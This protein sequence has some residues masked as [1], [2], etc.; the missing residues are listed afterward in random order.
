MAMTTRI[1]NHRS[2]HQAGRE[3]G[4]RALLGLLAII[5]A[6]ISLTA[7]LWRLTGPPEVPSGL[8]DWQYTRDVLRGSRVATGD[9]VS[10]AAAIGWIVL[11]YL[12]VTVSLR[13]LSE[14]AAHL[15]D[16]ARWAR[17]MLRLSDTI[18]LPPVR[19][20]VD[21]ALAGTLVAAAWLRSGPSMA[22]A[23]DSSL[24]ATTAVAEPHRLDP[25]GQY[26]S[27]L[28]RVKGHIAPTAMS[29]EA[30]YTVAE[31]DSL[32]RIAEQFY[33]DGSL[34]PAI[35]DANAGRSMVTGEAFTDP[36]L[37]RPGW[38]LEIP[39]P[40]EGESPVTPNMMYEVKEGD[41]LWRIAESVL[42]SGLR[43]TE[44]WE[45]NRDRD[46]GGG[47]PF[48]EA[49]RIFPGWVLE[50]PRP[51][52]LT[53]VP[54]IEPI[55]SPIAAPAPSPAA[56]TSGPT[57]HTA[58][59]ASPSPTSPA[60]DTLA[61]IS[62]TLPESNNGGGT[63]DLPTP[64]GGTVL[65]AAAGVGTA[66]AFALVVRQWRRRSD[67]SGIA[68]MRRRPSVGDAARAD[69]A[70]R[71]LSSALRDLGFEDV[72]ILLVRETQRVLKFTLGCAPGDADALAH[73]RYE[74]A[75]RLACAVDAAAASRTRV[76]FTLSRF[77]RL[78][79]MLLDRATTQPAVLLLPL[80]ATEAGIHYLTLSGVQSILLIGN[81]GAT[82]HMLS[83][84]ISSVKALHSAEALR[85]VQGG[86]ATSMRNAEEIAGAAEGR[87]IPELA[88]ELEDSIVARQS[89]SAP[90]A[91]PATISLAY[92]SE[93]AIDDLHHLETAIHRGPEH[94][95]Y[96]ICVAPQPVEIGNMFG[97]RIAFESA[98]AE[99]DELVLTLGRDVPIVLKPVEVHAQPLRRH[100]DPPADP[101]DEHV[102]FE[103]E[104]VDSDFKPAEEPE[105]NLVGSPGEISPPQEQP[106]PPEGTAL[107][108]EP[109]APGAAVSQGSRQAAL[110][111]PEP[112]ETNESASAQRPIFEVRCFGTF[113]VLSNGLEV[114]GWT[115]QKARELLAYLIARGGARVS[116]EEAAD[117]LWPE[118]PADQ[119]EHLLSNAAY[120]V[121]R[122]LKIATASPNGRVLT[123]SEQKYQ[124]LSGVFRADLDA[125][126]AHLR[127]AESLEGS[128]AL[129]E[130]DRALSIY[131]GEF[132]GNEPYEWAEPYRRDYQRRF[133]TAAHQAGRLAIECRDVKK[134][135]AFYQAILDRDPIDE[136]A[137]RALMRCHAKL[138]DTNAVRRVYKM[139]RESLR[140]ELDDERAEALPE[141]VALVGELTR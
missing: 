120:Y 21:A 71:S 95:I 85:F 27:G 22:T 84:W 141:T 55:A 87:S 19:R 26:Q 56:S 139:L 98:D 78:A 112:E 10:I 102:R 106:A 128:E 132:M 46:M 18:T 20:T 86:R 137:A 83:S 63:P 24:V 9:A 107:I 82:G 115:I 16:R 65:A 105:E 134:A 94:G 37:I 73:A 51:T 103:V 126:D 28:D 38:T 79:G 61:P 96:T 97:A 8:P 114:S 29:D 121:R 12:G 2:D 136:E 119:V 110:L 43:W 127:R 125:F 11:A 4:P 133:V 13:I 70:A 45:L 113:Q 117:A 77:Q 48:A 57:Q 3:G 7:L 76:E 89:S 74:V 60:P 101:V 116:R 50:L 44:I 108:S 81:E 124:L 40:A 49:S 104:R 99:P 130:Y 33:G 62:G 100:L 34:Y 75:R 41:S 14:G 6:T 30:P 122:T 80:G 35:F 135:M 66:A 59:P 138:G 93:D 140:R 42:G 1:R 67:G 23:A 5:A 31:G 54:I 111:V 91:E 39:P 109:R 52:E 88:R 90:R 64:L 17:A 53:Q 68:T 15:T 123:I 92:L 118:E 32:W 72:R 129:I 25:D 36:S 69:I 47:T 131:K 58:A